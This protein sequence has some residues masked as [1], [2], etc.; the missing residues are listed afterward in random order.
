VRFSHNGAELD[1]EG[2]TVAAAWVRGQSLPGMEPPR[3]DYRTDGAAYG[4]R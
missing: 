1:T 2:S 4:A 3:P